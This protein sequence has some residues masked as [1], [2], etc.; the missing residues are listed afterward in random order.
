MRIELARR[1]FE[2]LRRA[3]EAEFRR[4]LSAVAARCDELCDAIR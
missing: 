1:V 2:W 3:D 4:R